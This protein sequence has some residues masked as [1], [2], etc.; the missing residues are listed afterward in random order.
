[1]RISSLDFLRGIAIILVLFRHHNYFEY[2][3]KIGWIGVD[4]FFII[5]GFLVAGLFIEEYKNHKEVKPLQF[6]ARRGF[7]IYPLYYILF[8]FTLLSQTIGGTS[9]KIKTILG[10]IFF[11]QNY[12][13]TLN[14]HTWTLAIEEHFYFLL[15][16]LVVALIKF[17]KKET[18][19][20]KLIPLIFVFIFI[21][22]FAFRIYN[23]L[24]FPYSYNTHLFPS[25]LRFDSLF[26]G[27]LISYY[28]HFKRR[29]LENIVNGNIIILMVLSSLF[30]APCLVY[31]LETPLI[32]SLGITTLYIG[33]GGIFIIFILRINNN[34]VPKIIH[35]AYNFIASIGKYSYAIYLWH[36]TI[37]F[38]LEKILSLFLKENLEVIHLLIYITT[39]IFFGIFISRI[40]EGPFLKI[41][42]R[43]L[44]SRTVP[45]VKQAFYEPAKI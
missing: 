16:A 23:A 5:S 43:L 28:F 45:I 36:L 10:D 35:P 26:F 32:S 4:L 40:I 41:R 13:G 15:A 34:N 18:N 2:L 27:V 20:F 14:V 24:N 25:H 30:I 33:L 3:K 12:L 6:L 44:P 8:L 7:K 39:S 37:H 38:Y 22:C 17:G 11:L 9:Y 42:D 29:I 31:D 1:M 21:I 19:P